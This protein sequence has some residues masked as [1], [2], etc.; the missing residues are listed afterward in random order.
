MFAQLME[1]EEVKVNAVPN[2]GTGFAPYFLSLGLF[3]GALISTIII[4]MRDSEVIGAS[5]F[6]PVCQPYAYIHNDECASGA[7][8]CS[9]CSVRI[10]S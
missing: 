7:A 6:Q 8:R 2:Y 3:V 5:R 10:G 1:I 4:P 9:Y